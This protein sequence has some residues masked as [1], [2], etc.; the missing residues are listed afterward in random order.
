[1]CQPQGISLSDPGEFKYAVLSF[2]RNSLA[3]EVER[4]NRAWVLCNGLF[5]RQFWEGPLMLHFSSSC[6]NVFNK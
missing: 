5:E 6:I 2:P 1:M 3:L 4:I